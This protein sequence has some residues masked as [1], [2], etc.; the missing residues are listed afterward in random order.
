MVV[1]GNAEEWQRA[2]R[3]A[4]GCGGQVPP[5]LSVA[6]TA[7]VLGRARQIIGLDTGFTHLGAAFGR[8]T[9]GIYCD[10]EPGLAGITGGGLVASLGGKGQGPSREAVLAQLAVQLAR[11]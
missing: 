5:L 7:A 3:I 1:W 10:H 4:A 9:I 8:P 11:R 2:Q 6:E